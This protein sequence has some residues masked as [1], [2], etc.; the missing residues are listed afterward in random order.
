MSKAI[1]KLDEVLGNT[2]IEEKIT[3]LNEFQDVIVKKIKQGG[4]FISISPKNS[5]KSMAIALGSL[6]KSPKEFEGSPRVIIITKDV[7][8]ARAMQQQLKIWVRR[9]MIEAEVADD[10]GVMIQQR[11]DIFDGAEIIVGN[12]KRV[13]DLYIQN[14]INLRELVLMMVDDCEDVITSTKE[15]MYFMRLKDSLPQ[16]CQKA[17]FLSSITEKAEK[18]MDNFTDNAE[19]LEF[20]DD[21]I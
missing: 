8:T 7:T 10:K 9:T 1:Q 5:G 20:L 21:S 11:N 19:L 2:L 12:I 15:Y 14:G 18:L 6:I 3:T 13:Y 16:K 4:D 17:L